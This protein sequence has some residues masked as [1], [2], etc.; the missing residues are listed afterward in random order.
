M[1]MIQ[2]ETTKRTRNAIE[3]VFGHVYTEIA[4]ESDTEITINT[5]GDFNFKDIEEGR[6]CGW[7]FQRVAPRQD[8]SGREYI[9]ITFTKRFP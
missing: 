4:K 8:E 2:Q 3:Y 7:D 9:A 1:T 5:F 6:C